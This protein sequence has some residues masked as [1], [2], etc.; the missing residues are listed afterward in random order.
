MLVFVPVASWIC[1]NDPLL[2]SPLLCLP[3]SLI[4]T[5]V[6]VILGSRTCADDARS[7]HRSCTAG[8][9]V[10]GFRKTDRYVSFGLRYKIKGLSHSRH[11]ER[12]GKRERAR[13]TRRG[14][15]YDLSSGVIFNALDQFIVG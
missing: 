3:P 12:E 5:R 11:E 4:S 2:S 15:E 13:R 8:G 7:L 6:S 14:G 9:D 1:T 10:W